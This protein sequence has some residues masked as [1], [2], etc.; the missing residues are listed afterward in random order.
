M[1]PELVARSL[2]KLAALKGRQ[3]HIESEIAGIVGV[4][5]SPDTQGVTE[6]TWEEIG[7]ALGVSR[8]AAWQR[9]GPHT[10]QGRLV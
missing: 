10:R 9:Y 2:S 6:T 8:Q 1:T 4:L 5:M 3:Q 7:S